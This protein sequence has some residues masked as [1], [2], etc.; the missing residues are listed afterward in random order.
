[1][2]AGG[3]SMMLV[4]YNSAYLAPQVRI[5][6]QTLA[7]RNV[8]SIIAPVR[9]ERGRHAFVLG[10]VFQRL[11]SCRSRSG[12]ISLQR[13]LQPRLKLTNVRIKS[14]RRHRRL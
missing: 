3:L 5:T 11:E 4:A 6:V 13:V 14:M 10:L 8:L 2:R 12:I 9:F 7:G 1:M